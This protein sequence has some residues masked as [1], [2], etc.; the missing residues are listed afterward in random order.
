MVARDH[1]DRRVGQSRAETVQLLE[2]KQ[3]CGIGRPHGME[4]VSR[5][6]DQ[7]RA[8]DEQVVHR[9]AERFG[10]VGL[11]LISSPRRLPVVLAE[12]EVQIGQVRE[13]HDLNTGRRRSG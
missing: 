8:L 2:H 9:A 7:V 3:D 10:H 4:D 5:K 1:H 12:P 6:D 13:L 11:A